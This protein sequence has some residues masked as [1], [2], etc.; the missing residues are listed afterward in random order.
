MPTRRDAGMDHAIYPFSALPTRPPFRL[1]TRAQVA[2]FVTLYIEHWELLPP[3]TVYRDPRMRGEFGAY[4]PDFR[5]WS[6]REYGNRI[7]IYR[8]LDLLQRLGLRASVA[9]NAMAAERHPHLVHRARAAGHEPVAH[10]IAATRMITSR[11]DEAAERAEIMD[12][13]DRLAAV[14][15][16]RAAGWCGQDAGATPRTSTLLAELGFRYTLDWPNDEQP[17]WHNPDRSLVAVPAQTEW[18]DLQLLGLRR[19]P[20]QNFPALVADGLDQLAIEASASAR[21]MGIGVHPWML[22][23][24]HRIRYLVET[25]EAVAARSD[26]VVATAGE[27]ATWYADQTRGDVVPAAVQAR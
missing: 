10:G 11:M 18:D 6:M 21:V 3:D 16:A 17:Y 25:L 7:G 5:F 2:F 15:G 24:P 26:V 19:V 12:A 23:A 22:G 9:I 27:I 14:W 8:I 13:T 1:P 4:T 20:V